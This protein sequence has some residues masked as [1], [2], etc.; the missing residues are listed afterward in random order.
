[1]TFEKLSGANAWLSAAEK[2]IAYLSFSFSQ[3][4]TM[5]NRQ[6]QVWWNCPEQETTGP[7]RCINY[8]VAVLASPPVTRETTIFP[9]LTSDCISMFVI[10]EKPLSIY[11][12]PPSAPHECR[13]SVY[14]LLYSLISI[15]RR[16][17][18]LPM[19]ISDFI[20]AWIEISVS[21]IDHACECLHFFFLN[22]FLINSYF[23]YM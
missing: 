1:M 11:I 7:A 16:R 15:E 22:N 18:A 20:P 21:A 5:S 2:R 13:L 6:R 10:S 14:P 3:Q 17:R 8:L 4:A 23:L 9:S 19:I 12:P